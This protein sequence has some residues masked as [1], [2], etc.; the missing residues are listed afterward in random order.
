MNYVDVRGFVTIFVH[1]VGNVVCFDIFI[2]A[3]SLPLVG[4]TVV[5]E[6]GCAMDVNRSSIT[7]PNILCDFFILVQF[8]AGFDIGGVI[9]FSNGDVIYGLCAY[10]INRFF[11]YVVG[12][13]SNG[14]TY[15]SVYCVCKCVVGISDFV[16]K[17]M[18]SFDVDV[19]MT[20]APLRLIGVGTV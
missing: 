11:E 12:M 3:G 4:I 17:L 5:E 18:I 6:V 19:L 1:F 10:P 2:F 14:F 7:F 16:F 15:L 8:L 13:F 9:M 20:C